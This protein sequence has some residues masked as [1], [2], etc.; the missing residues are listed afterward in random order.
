MLIKICLSAFLSWGQRILSDV[1]G[2]KKKKS[3]IHSVLLSIAMQN[4]LLKDKMLY[5]A[6]VAYSFKSTLQL[7]R[8]YQIAGL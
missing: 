8:H 3:S 6:E 1:D 5:E 2:K 4:R 7:A